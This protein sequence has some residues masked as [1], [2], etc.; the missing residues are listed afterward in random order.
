MAQGIG[1]G[2]DGS[3]C[4]GR[5]HPRRRSGLKGEDIVSRP[6]S[7]LAHKLRVML[8]EK[9]RTRNPQRARFELKRAWLCDWSLVSTSP[10]TMV[11]LGNRVLWPVLC[12]CNDAW[13]SREEEF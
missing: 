5:G 12:C 11:W 10:S 13:P 3:G 1:S 8:T 7:L 9:Q 6:S 2:Q 4:I